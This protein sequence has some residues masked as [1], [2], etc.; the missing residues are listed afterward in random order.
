M[1]RIFKFAMHFSVQTQFIYVAAPSIGFAKETL[2]RNY[3]AR[4][5][6]IKTMPIGFNNSDVHY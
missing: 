2:E 1:A 4:V 3:S 5:E 6:Y